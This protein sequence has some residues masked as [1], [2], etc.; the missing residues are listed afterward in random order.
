VARVPPRRALLP[1]PPAA[2]TLLPPAL[3]GRHPES[4]PFRFGVW[5]RVQRVTA[6]Q[7]S[8][9]TRVMVWWVQPANLPCT[10]SIWLPTG[11]V[12]EHLKCS[13]FDNFPATLVR[14]T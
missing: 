2:A 1:V 11:N 14:G 12:R 10:S 8:V 4:P 3:S 5:R 13:P 9:A 6:G 7:V